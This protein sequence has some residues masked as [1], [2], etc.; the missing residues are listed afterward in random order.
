MLVHDLPHDRHNLPHDRHDLPHDRHDL[1]HDRHDLHND[2]Q[3]FGEGAGVKAMPVPMPIY[4]CAYASD[5][6]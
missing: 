3:G 1:P 5:H 6:A 2:R 4:A